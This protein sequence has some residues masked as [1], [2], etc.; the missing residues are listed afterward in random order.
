MHPDWFNPLNI[1]NNNF[2]DKSKILCKNASQMWYF[3]K[4]NGNSLIN[5][6]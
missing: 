6:I 3:S 5:S 2:L 4:S 1:D